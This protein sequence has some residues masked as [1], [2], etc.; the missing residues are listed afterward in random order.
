VEIRTG[1]GLRSV[2]A[3]ESFSTGYS[4]PPSPGPQQNSNNR[5]LV[6]LFLGIGA[7]VAALVVAITGKDHELPCSGGVVILSPTGGGPG[8]CQ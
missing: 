3:G 7:G 4:T 6:W 8:I 5:K 2:T 1:N